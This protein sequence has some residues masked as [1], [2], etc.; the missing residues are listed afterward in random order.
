MKDRVDRSAERGGPRNGDRGD[1][2]PKNG[3]E[4]YGDEEDFGDGGW[5]GY[6]G[7]YRGEEIGGIRS[8]TYLATHIM[9]LP[10]MDGPSASNASSIFIASVRSRWRRRWSPWMVMP[11]YGI[12]GRTG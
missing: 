11:F 2:S 3:E 12:S 5:G 7:G 10:Q 6:A 8:W 9:G 4:K 1:G